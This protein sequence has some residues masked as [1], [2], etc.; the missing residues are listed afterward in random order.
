MFLITSLHILGYSKRN[1]IIYTVKST[2]ILGR[3][4]ENNAPLDN[5]KLVRGSFHIHI[6]QKRYSLFEIQLIN[7]YFKIIL[8]GLAF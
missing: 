8:K 4:F 5:P 6:F 1:E 3:P 2:N 7:E